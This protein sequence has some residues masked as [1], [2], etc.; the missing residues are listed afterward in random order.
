M[1]MRVS[2][3]L[4]TAAKKNETTMSQM[5]SLLK[6]EKAA[7]NGMILVKTA[8][9]TDSSAQA[10]VGRGSNIRPAQ[11]RSYVCP[12]CA[13]RDRNIQAC[14]NKCRTK[15]MQQSQGEKASS[16]MKRR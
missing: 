2:D 11:G 8:N 4:L 1:A 7:W 15:C 9:V 5:A 10:P 13:A 12:C 16:D 14:I 6:A 3:S